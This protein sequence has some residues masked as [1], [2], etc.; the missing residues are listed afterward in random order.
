MHR[1]GASQ[2][3]DDIDGILNTSGNINMMRHQK[4]IEEQ[5]RDKMKKRQNM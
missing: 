4:M 5:K 2:E 3:H 1:R